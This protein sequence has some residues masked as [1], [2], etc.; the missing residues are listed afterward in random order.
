MNLYDDPKLQLLICLL[1]AHT[2]ADFTLQTRSDVKTKRN[3][4]TLI[5]HT[6]THAGLAYLFAGLWTAWILPPAV[7]VSHAAIDAVKAR[8]KEPGARAFLVDQAVHVAATAALAVWLAPD[9]G[10]LYWVELAGSVYLKALILITG[11]VLTVLAGGHLIALAV[12]PFLSQLEPPA[13]D[14][15]EATSSDRLG[16]PA[17]GRRGMVAGDRRGASLPKGRGFPHGGLVIGRLERALIL[18]FVLTGNPA[19]IGFLFAAKSILR[20]G[21]VRDSQ[22][23]MEAEY[24]II[25]TLM[26]FGY[27]MLLAYVTRAALMQS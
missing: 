25:G 2:L 21:E 5:R 17:P 9:R 26:S 3:W 20:F 22:H 4:T 1:A 16:T 8:M 14:R 13:A 23:R 24:I 15:L 6:A 11:T 18:L 19:G 12:R 27:G 7:L 10:G